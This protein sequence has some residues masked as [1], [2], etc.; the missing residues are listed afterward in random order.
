MEQ[1]LSTAQLLGVSGQTVLAFAVLTWLIV[2]HFICDF[3]LQSAYQAT[4]KG[5]Y[6]HPAGLI[7]IGIHGLG[8]APLFLLSAMIAP[9]LLAA[10]IALELLAHYHIDWVKQGLGARM[11]WTPEDRAFWIAMGADQFLHHAT[12]VAM[13][14]VV[15]ASANASASGV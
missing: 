15:V 3:V 4:Y 13:T 12:Y 11:G 7:H 1:F 6:G 5:V 10:V 8:S 2:K 9:T 14:L